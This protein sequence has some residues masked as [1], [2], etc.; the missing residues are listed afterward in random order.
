M[1]DDHTPPPILVIHGEGHLGGPLALELL[2]ADGTR[3]PLVHDAPAAAGSG[4]RPI[5]EQVAAAGAVFHDVI[6]DL[7]AVSW[8]NSTGLGWLVG[9]V[10]DRKQAGGSVALAGTNDRI[11]N[12]LE[13]TA[14]ALVLPNHA[15]VDEAAR[16]LRDTPRGDHGG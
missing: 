3:L 4:P 5:L 2:H 10:R 7:A 12:L 9:L 14:L 16:A 13:T 6:V 8:L 15:T 1:T 11:A